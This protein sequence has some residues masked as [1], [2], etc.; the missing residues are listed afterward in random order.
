MSKDLRSGGLAALSVEDIVK[1]GFST[2]WDAPTVPPFPFSFRNCEVL[3]LVWRTTEAAVARILPPPLTPTSDVVLAHVYQMN[4]TD[5]LGPYRESN[6]S[7]GAHFGPA[8]LS[9][10]YSPYL[11]L[12]SD[13]GVVHGRE[14]HG[15][16][17]KL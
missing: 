10:S 2:P 12:S 1:P 8:K 4:D 9:G 5:W 15:Q 6:I 17:K 7:V 3:T 11:F 16:P 14:V 13:V